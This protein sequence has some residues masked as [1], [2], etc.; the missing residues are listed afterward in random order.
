MEEVMNSRSKVAILFSFIIILGFIYVFFSGKTP[1]EQACVLEEE[2]QYDMSELKKRGFDQ[3]VVCDTSTIKNIKRNDLMCINE[4]F[5]FVD[6]VYNGFIGVHSPKGQ[7]ILSNV[8]ILS[9][10][11]SIYKQ[12]TKEYFYAKSAIYLEVVRKIKEMLK[13]KEKKKEQNEDKIKLT[14]V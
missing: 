3:G 12:N 8:D 13:E 7:F 10:P 9:V 1:Y 6:S 5:V 11:S 2:I 14:P 4:S